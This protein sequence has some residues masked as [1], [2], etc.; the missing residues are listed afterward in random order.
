M[1]TFWWC[2]LAL[3]TVLL[4]GGIG[5]A[6]APD[7]GIKGYPI[8]IASS[9][10]ATDVPP[11]ECES[12]M[13]DD[14][15]ANAE[16]RRKRYIKCVLSKSADK[17]STMDLRGKQ[18]ARVGSGFFVATDGTLVTNSRLVDDCTLLSISPTFGE[19]RAAV[20]IASDPAVD[21]AL[22]GVEVV[23]PG[24]AGFTD[25]DGV[26]TNEPLYVV[27][28]PGPGTTAGEPTL[29]SVQILGSQKTAVSVS[30]LVIE[31]SILSGNN[32]GALLDSSGGVIGVVLANSTQTYAATGGTAE[33]VGLALPSE[34]VQRF[35]QKHG[36][37]GRVG[38]KGSP[39][40]EDRLLIDARPFMAQVGC[41]Q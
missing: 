35:L 33:T 26:L 15:A 13:A 14:D 23:P 41:W 31:G 5:Q 10:E 19:M 8:V 6:D 16:Q 7:D 1:H 11:G 27:G 39:K 17:S 24:T 32:G 3:M 9:P 29:T 12:A 21:L 34:A 18:L 40:S 37:E 20:A 22:L 4:G 38:L 36:V 25:S 28:Y 2:G 30:T